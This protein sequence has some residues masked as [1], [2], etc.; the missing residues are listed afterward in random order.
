MLFLAPRHGHSRL[1]LGMA[2]FASWIAQL[3]IISSQLA[4]ATHT[5]T[6]VGVPQ[7]AL[8]AYK[9]TADVSAADVSKVIPPCPALPFAFR[10]PYC[11]STLSK[12]EGHPTMSRRTCTRRGAAPFAPRER[13]STG[14][15]GGVNER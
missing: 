1:S 6:R 5:P 7:P 11:S 10:K 12:L 15:G 2:L 14:W 9:V 4:A 13:M 8:D 3:S